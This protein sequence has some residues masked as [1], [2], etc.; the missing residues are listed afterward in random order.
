MHLFSWE[1]EER[2][3]LLKAIYGD[4]AYPGMAEVN[5]HHEERDMIDHQLV[6]PEQHHERQLWKKAAEEEQERHQQEPP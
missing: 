1:A 4:K 3:A 6:I 5:I 2:V